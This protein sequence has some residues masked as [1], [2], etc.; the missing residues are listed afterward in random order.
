MNLAT[1]FLAILAQ[2]FL[3][4]DVVFFRPIPFA[5]Q[6]PAVDE[7]TDDVEML[8]FR[9]AQDCSTTWARRW[10]GSTATLKLR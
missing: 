2:Q 10:L 3:D 8:A 4:Q 5:A 6:L 1:R 9:I 7:I